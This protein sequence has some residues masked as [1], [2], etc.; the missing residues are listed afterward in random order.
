MQTGKKITTLQDQIRSS[1]ERVTHTH[2]RC[3]WEQS[4]SSC[5]QWSYEG[6]DLCD[7]I[8]VG[9]IENCRRMKEDGAVRKLEAVG[10]IRGRDLN[11]RRPFDLVGNGSVRVRVAR[12]STSG[13]RGGARGRQ[14][15]VG[16]GDDGEEG[17]RHG[18][19]QALADF[20]HEPPRQPTAQA[21]QA[22]RPG[23][24]MLKKTK[25]RER[26]R[27]YPC[28]FLLFIDKRIQHVFGSF[29]S[30]K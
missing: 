30:T 17:E 13:E 1:R 4:L 20:Y 27:I 7:L 6:W 16:V 26:T 12:N 15:P 21:Q 11:C 25:N 8:D 18:G 5:W 2:H 28:R 10:R 29:F 3:S 19:T 22:T 24:K 14:R 9:P 23:P